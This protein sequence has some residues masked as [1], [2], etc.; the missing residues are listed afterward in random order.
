MKETTGKGN[1]S[2]F[3]D[4]HFADSERKNREKEREMPWHF[5]IDVRL[6][7]WSAPIG[8]EPTVADV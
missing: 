6:N 2:I 4:R 3:A 8:A 5:R 1:I 7:K